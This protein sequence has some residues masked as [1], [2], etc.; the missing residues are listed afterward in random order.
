MKR[1]ERAN[2]GWSADLMMSQRPFVTPSANE[3][4]R[5]ILANRRAEMQ[6]P[7]FARNDIDMGWDVMNGFGMTLGILLPRSSA[8]GSVRYPCPTPPRETGSGVMGVTSVNVNAISARM[9]PR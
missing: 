3:G 4:S 8:C 7:H 9:A 5:I 1:R 6:P 2:T